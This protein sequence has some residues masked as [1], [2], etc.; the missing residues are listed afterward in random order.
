M[1][2]L[3]STSWCRFPIKRAGSLT[4]RISSRRST[5]LKTMKTKS[6]SI[7]S[8]SR[9]WYKETMCRQWSGDTHQKSTWSAETMDPYMS[10]AL[11]KLSKK[12]NRGNPSRALMRRPSMRRVIPSSLILR[13]SNLSKPSKCWEM[14]KWAKLSRCRV[15]RAIKSNIWWMETL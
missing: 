4:G 2:K 12:S 1:E 13:G 11:L 10:M 14:K 3:S 5:L 8:R 9:A 7:C 6:W 15:W